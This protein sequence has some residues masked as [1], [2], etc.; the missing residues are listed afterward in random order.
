MDLFF[1]FFRHKFLAFIRS[2]Y[3][4]HGKVSTIAEVFGKIYIF[5][6]IGI[7]AFN[8][9]YVVG[10]IAPD[11][12]IVR[13]IEK[14]FF[15]Y[16]L[17]DFIVRWIFQTRSNFNLTPYLTL[18]IKKKKLIRFLCFEEMLSIF[19]IYSI[20]FFAAASFHFV[21]PIYGLLIGISWTIS[22]LSIVFLVDYIVRYLQRNLLLKVI[23]V[24]AGVMVMLIFR[25]FD[26]SFTFEY[27][28]L[29]IFIIYPIF[30]LLPASS[31]LIVGTSYVSYC[32]SKFYNEKVFKYRKRKMLQLKL[33]DSLF[34]YLGISG[35]F[36]RLELKLIIRN[37]R[38]RQFLVASLGMLCYIY[39]SIVAT[40]QKES[41]PILVYGM[42]STGIGIGMM[43]YGQLMYGWE[44]SYFDLILTR[45]ISFREYL[46]AKRLLLLLF[47]FLGLI[48]FLPITFFI[49]GFIKFLFL[50]FLTDAGVI[51][52]LLILWANYNRRVIHLQRT[53]LFNYEGINGAQFL[54]MAVI[55]VFISV[56]LVPFTIL[57]HSDTG[58]LVLGFIGL[59]S[60][61]MG[62][63][64]DI[65]FE[66]V[67]KRYKYNIADS[68]RK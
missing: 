46:R 42:T 60:V 19:N 36:L 27:S 61:V 14:Y 37:K 17:T 30:C 24:I 34:S 8:L 2:Q 29:Q 20:V 11:Q 18:P 15:F 7:L 12:N 63:Q 58:L 5:F 13:L 66:K 3:S 53:T 65:F 57:G 6:S 23:L 54:G 38:P 44:G 39:Y 62:K 1:I 41:N 31:V 32:N 35:E 40:A 43:N 55:L 64:W 26:R 28:Y 4:L 52:P 10:R 33:A 47:C 49:P 21:V 51:L 25:Y 45:P 67:F 56:I 16:I 59:V 48:I 50:G 9:D 68:F 22:A